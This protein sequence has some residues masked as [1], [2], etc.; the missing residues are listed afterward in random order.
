MAITTYQ[1]YL[2]HKASGE[3]SYSKLVDIT[4][5]PNIGG[6][7]EGVE[8]TTLSDKIR[9]FIAGIENTE[10]MVFGANFDK[11][12][13]STLKALGGAD[14]L[15]AVWFGASDS[16]GTMVPDGHN[17]K[18]SFTGQ[19]SVYLTG[20]GVNEAVAMEISIFPSTEIDFT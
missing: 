19:L 13:F 10:T 4:S 1:T 7:A 14:E 18:F 8:I 11:T 6:A 20:G 16:S 2:M 12:D 3:S 15:Y 9:K 17:G 5:F